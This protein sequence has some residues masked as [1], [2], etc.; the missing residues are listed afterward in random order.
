MSTGDVLQ[1]TA[2]CT[3][4][5]TTPCGQQGLGSGGKNPSLPC[6]GHHVFGSHDEHV[7]SSTDAKAAVLRTILLRLSGERDTP[8]SFYLA[9]VLLPVIKVD[10]RRK[11]TEHVTMRGVHGLLRDVWPKYICSCCFTAILQSNSAGN[12]ITEPSNSR[13]S[14]MPTSL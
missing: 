6:Q 11:S 2:S 12:C 13:S 5:A 4:F 8:L 9:A 1:S 14:C 10:L 3:H 7:E